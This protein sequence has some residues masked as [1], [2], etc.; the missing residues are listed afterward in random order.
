MDTL[1]EQLIKIEK[2]I[3]NLQEV[4]DSEREFAEIANIRFHNNLKAFSEFYPK[5]A[6]EIEKFQPRDELKLHVTKSG[7]GNAV[8][9]ESGVLLYAD[10][11]VK[12][13]VEQVD[14][15]LSQPS[16][17]HIDFSSYASLSDS[18]RRLHT[19]Y[20]KKLGKVIEKV[21]VQ[22]ISNVPDT[23]PTAMVF[24][25]G[26][27]YHVIELVERIDFHNVF[28]IEPNF[29]LFYLSLFCVDWDSVI[30]SINES[31]GTLSFYLGSSFESFIDDIYS[32]SLYFGAQSVSKNFFY[33]HYP[34][35]EIESLILTCRQ[36][37]HE[38]HLGH[39]FYNDATTALAHTEKNL[40]TGESKLFSKSIDVSENKH[41]IPAV[42]V[43]NGPSLDG[44]IDILKENQSSVIIISAGSSLQTLLKHGITPDFHVL[45][46]RTKSTYDVVVN[47]V[48]KEILEKINLLTLT[49][50]YPEVTNL[51][52]WVGMTGKGRDA[53]VSLLNLTLLNEDN[54][55]VPIAPYGN[56]L[57]SNLAL[58]YAVL[59][60]FKDIYLMGVDNAYSL[61]GL[62]HSKSSDH[63]K[64]KLTNIK[65]AP[66]KR[67]I[68][69][70]LGGSLKTTELLAMSCHQMGR[71]LTNPISKNVTCYNVGHGAKIKGALPLA[72]RHILIEPS[73]IE[74]K[75]ALIDEIKN[76][77][78]SV[79]VRTMEHYLDLNFFQNLCSD[80][81]EIA[82]SEVKDRAEA[83]DSIRKQYRYLTAYR[84]TKYEHLMF[85][86]EGEML[87]FHCP[88]ISILYS[89]DDSEE[90]LEK[91][92]EANDVWLEALRAIKKGFKN[93]WLTLCDLSWEPS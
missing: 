25:I 62:H 6:D 54:R 39:G 59:L 60:G 80:V 55:S 61:D 81:I 82:S 63:Y 86:L 77:F 32:T 92:L 57:V 30:K 79:S 64:G 83:L 65:Q 29:E 67:D 7:H 51:Y 91:Y 18:D 26:L 2:K 19:I 93:D 56:P 88:L 45:V 12:Q 43:G 36:R 31:N 17:N 52:G 11:P 38:L 10:D 58:S 21:K 40:A 35:K 76:N 28:L 78:T 50:I 37:L 71:L 9:P 41:K 53:S 66:A 24:G 89:S 3:R 4:S 69:G 68:E 23:F 34:S 27:G 72:P 47:T 49:L 85:V 8:E 73:P 48:P 33:V 42:V 44:V 87:Y 84:G 20:L 14:K 74:A 46:E 16:I 13:A 5:V 75:Q 22:G 90:C 15:S 70:N 1:S